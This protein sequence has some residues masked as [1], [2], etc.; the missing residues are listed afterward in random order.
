[1]EIDSDNPDHGFQF[2]GVFEL[3][4]LGPAEAGLERQLPQLL[5]DGGVEVQ[6]GGVRW[7]ASSN[8]RYV[9]VRIAFLARD[10]A[11]Y[12]L[13]HELLRGH[14]EVKWTL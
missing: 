13:A 14:P 5:A 11:Q 6:P 7:K 9:S 12:D 8:G 3:S 10:R 4:A 2:P 1:M